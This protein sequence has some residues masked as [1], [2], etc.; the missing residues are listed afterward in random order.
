[1]TL[2]G[3]TPARP[4]AASCLSL[5]LPLV[6][7]GSL[8]V[9]L[10]VAFPQLG[11]TMFYGVGLDASMP[12]FL[13]ALGGG[14]AGSYTTIAYDLLDGQ[15]QDENRWILNLWPPGVPFLLWLIMVVNGGALPIVPFVVITGVLWAA[16]LTLLSALLIR[17]RAF[18]ML[19]LFALAWLFGPLLTGWTVHRGAISSD[20]ISAALTVILAAGL[21]LIG[22][23]EFENVRGWR[24]HLYF[25]GI[26]LLLGV[27]CLFRVTWLFAILASSA[28]LVLYI[29]FRALIRAARRRRGRDAPRPLARTLPWVAALVGFAIVV[30]PWT[31]VVG[32]VI[33]PGNYSWSQGEY[34]WAQTW[35]NDEQLAAI[36]YARFLI[37]GEVNWAC[38]LDPMQ[39]AQLEADESARDTPYDGQGEHSFTDFARR[40]I[41]TAVGN[42]VPFIGSRSATTFVTWMSVPGDRVGAWSSVPFGIVSLLA[43]VSAL[44]L[45]VRD[46]VRGRSGAFLLLM[47]AG[48]NLGMIWLSHFETRYLMP[49]QTIGLV[50]VAVVVSRQEAELWRRARERRKHQ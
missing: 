41:L 45:L 7:A 42:P 47:L 13:A 21:L 1:M 32:R 40:A 36:P 16:A 30:V 17:R 28:A 15:I 22:E 23:P 19:G 4:T 43:F 35:M 33:H 25:G 26:G 2:L 11:D 18:L 50:V 20:G 24:R 12:Q 39:C 29:S 46:S 34:Q 3:R 6:F 27:L 44:V 14:D 49:L 31:A 9:Y 5:W 48:A 10:G 38:D 37:D 8:L